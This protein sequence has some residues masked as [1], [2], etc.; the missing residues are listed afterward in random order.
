MTY[1]TYFVDLFVCHAAW[2]VA[3]IMSSRY[4]SQAIMAFA[5][6]KKTSPYKRL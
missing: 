5:N 2:P 3:L 6:H 1:L 4:L